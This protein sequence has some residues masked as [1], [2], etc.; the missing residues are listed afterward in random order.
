MKRE[1]VYAFTTKNEMKANFAEC[2]NRTLKGTHQHQYIEVLQDTKCN[3]RL[4]SVYS[5]GHSAI[6]F[7]DLNPFIV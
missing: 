7:N 3:H 2:V 6:C 4:H 5:E 1:S